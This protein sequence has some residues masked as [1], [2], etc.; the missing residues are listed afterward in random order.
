MK[1]HK[2]SLMVAALA[3]LLCTI[4]TGRAAD[5]AAPAKEQEAPP[6]GERGARQRDR[7]E[8][9]A[10]QLDLTQAQKDQLKPILQ[11]EGEKVRALRQDTSLTQEQRRE[12]MKAIRDEIAPEIKKVLTAEQFT[13]WEKMRQERPNRGGPNGPGAPGSNGT[14]RPPAPK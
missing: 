1:F 4:P 13:K 7:V 8:Q 14:N 5:T 11:K 2:T 10:K 6:A 3:G 9:I 12:K